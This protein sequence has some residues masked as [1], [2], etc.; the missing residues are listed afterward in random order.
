MVSFPT[1]IKTNRNLYRWWGTTRRY[2]RSILKVR[3][4]P[5]LSG[6]ENIASNSWC[7]GVTEH[8]I[9]FRRPFC[10]QHAN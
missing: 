3:V 9:A 1:G 5:R 8:Q 7:F 2:K 6:K 10:A 4:C